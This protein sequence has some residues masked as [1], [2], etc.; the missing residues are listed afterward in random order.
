MARNDRRRRTWAEIAQAV[1]RLGLNRQQRRGLLKASVRAVVAGFVSWLLVNP[2]QS[3]ALAGRGPNMILNRGLDNFFTNSGLHSSTSETDYFIGLR[4]YF[5]VGTGATEPAVG[6]TNLVAEVMRGNSSGGFANSVAYTLD[7]ANNRIIGEFSIVRVL[8]FTAAYNLPEFGFSDI[9]SGQV[10]IRELFRNNGVAFTLSVQA[11][12]QLQMTHT[13]KVAIPFANN[14]AANA[15]ITG[16]GVLPGKQTFF[17]NA[18]ASL[19][20]WMFYTGLSPNI[21]GVVNVKLLTGANTGDP[22]ALGGTYSGSGANTVGATTDAYV[23]GSYKRTKTIVYA[24]S[25]GNIPIYGWM[26]QD[27]GSGSN[28]APLGGWR[29]TLTTPFTKTVAN[30]LTLVYELEIAR[31]AI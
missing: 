26:F 21:S 8:D 27:Q 6:Q 11:G 10:N 17:V 12:Q 24:T 5:C 4:T 16:M 3:V 7:A 30:K 29:F 1:A 2:D 20:K 14:L 15:D 19:Y 25:A 23:T 9:A 31:A 13:L 18:S 28:G 22:N